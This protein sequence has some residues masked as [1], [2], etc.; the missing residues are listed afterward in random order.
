LWIVDISNPAAPVLVGSILDMTPASDIE[1]AGSYVYLTVGSYFA[2]RGLQSVDISNP[3]APVLAGFTTM[4]PLNKASVGDPPPAMVVAGDYAYVA[5]GEAGLATVNIATPAT[6]KL[7]GSVDWGDTYSNGL[8]MENGYLHVTKLSYPLRTYLRILDIANP[9]MPV[10]VDSIDMP[11]VSAYLARVGAYVWVM[12]DTDSRP[13]GLQSIDISNPAAPLPAGFIEMP[14]GVYD[15]VTAGK[16]IYLAYRNNAQEIKGL[17]IVDIGN[18]AAPVLAG[19]IPD[20]P[21]DIVV[22]EEYLYAAMGE[23]GLHI[24]NISNPAAPVLAGSLDTPGYAQDLAVAGKYVYLVDYISDTASS[25]LRIVNIS[26]PAAPVLAGSLDMP[27]DFSAKR[28]SLA[29]GYAYVIGGNSLLIFNINNPAAPVLAGSYTIPLDNIGSD[30]I[31]DIAVAGDIIYVATD[32]HRLQILRAAVWPR[33]MNWA[34]AVY[35]S[36]FPAQGKREITIAPY[37]VRFYTDSFY[38]NATYLGYNPLDERFYGY[39]PALFGPGI[40]PFGLLSEYLPGV[41][42]AGF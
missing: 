1:V 19:A 20:A 32:L 11:G 21:S 38:N 31:N 36:L 16:Y 12:T 40:V 37:L 26:N 4:N 2:L 23:G 30:K 6:P 15:A 13:Y 25:I 39:N 9:A 33:V 41:R 24:T 28:V 17:Q 35:P 34:E 27:S 8:A 10:V 14:A 18:P 5:H 42:A 3:A 22:A 7:A 29:S